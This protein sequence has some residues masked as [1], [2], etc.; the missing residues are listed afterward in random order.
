LNYDPPIGAAVAQA[1]STVTILE[2]RVAEL[3]EAIRKKEVEQKYAKLV[4]TIKEL[5][6]I[7]VPIGATI[8]VVGKGDDEL[9]DLRGRNA[10]HF[11]R[12]VNGKFAG[13]YPA[14]S[15]EAISHLEN[16]RGQGAK[17]LLIPSTSFWWLEFYTEFTNHLQQRHRLVT[18]Q[19]DACIIYQLAQ[20]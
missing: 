11:P 12:A 15:G 13:C 16:L 1:P 18:Y 9:L 19:D 6:Q 20:E 4:H 8:L 14:N 7:T 17:Y 2:N 3:Q 10:W 5:V